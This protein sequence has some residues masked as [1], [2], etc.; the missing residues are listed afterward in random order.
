MKQKLSRYSIALVVTLAA[1]FCLN[2]AH[3][4]LAQ[5]TRELIGSLVWTT[6]TGTPATTP[7]AGSLYTEKATGGVYVYTGAAWKQAATVGVAS[8]YKLARGVQTTVAAVDTV[9]TG[10][11]TVV[12]CSATMGDDPGDDPEWTSC[13][14]GDQAGAPAAGSIYVKTWK[15]TAGTDPT[16]TAATTFTKKVNWLA[17]GT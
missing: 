2:V 16:P 11:A 14:I 9:V 10:L 13:S 8:G 4:T 6:G 5:D 12:S 1:V 7:V 15:N 3:P 17:I